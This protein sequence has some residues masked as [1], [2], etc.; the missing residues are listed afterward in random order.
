MWPIA[1]YWEKSDVGKASVDDEYAQIRIVKPQS[2]FRETPNEQ[3]QKNDRRDRKCVEKGAHESGRLYSDSR[4]MEGGLRSASFHPM[5]LVSRTRRLGRTRKR[6]RW[7]PT[8]EPESMIA[9]CEGHDRCPFLQLCWTGRH[10]FKSA[11]VRAPL[12]RRTRRLG[13]RLALQTTFARNR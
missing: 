2:T 1:I 10:L 13:I 5:R 9:Q 3:A 8:P 6:R 7:R 11:L 4:G 12:V